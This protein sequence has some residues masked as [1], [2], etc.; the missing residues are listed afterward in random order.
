MTKILT[1]IMWGEHVCVY[2]CF[3]HMCESKCM[4]I[5]MFTCGR[6]MS[7]SG[8][9]HMYHLP[10]LLRQSVSLSFSR[11]GWLASKPHDLVPSSRVL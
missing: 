3:K 9:F 6:Q 10:C 11:Q 2:V 5:G 1:Q 8:F 4:C 7:I